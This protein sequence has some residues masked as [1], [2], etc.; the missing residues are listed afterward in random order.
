MCSKDF[1]IFFI[2]DLISL[3]QLVLNFRIIQCLIFTIRIWLIG[4][5]A[6]WRWSSWV[7]WKKPSRLLSTSTTTTWEKTTICECPSPNPPSSTPFTTN[8]PFPHPPHTSPSTFS[9]LTVSFRD[10]DWL[11]NSKKKNITDIHGVVLEISKK[12]KQEKKQIRDYCRTFRQS[13]SEFV[14]LS[15]NQGRRHMGYPW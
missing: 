8:T 2:L 4:R 11:T 15:R 14:L 6:R 9:S 1:K 3:D 5:T 10:Q 7:Q 13:E 12:K